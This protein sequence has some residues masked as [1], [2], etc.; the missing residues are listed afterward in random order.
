MG[1]ASVRLPYARLHYISYTL[2]A[3]HLRRVHHHPLPRAGRSCSRGIAYDTLI[4]HAYVTRY[5]IPSSF[6]GLYPLF[7]ASGRDIPESINRFIPIDRR[8]SGLNHSNG[9]EHSQRGTI[10]IDYLQGD[11]ER[12]ITAGG[13]RVRCSGVGRRRSHM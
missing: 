3:L 10:F 2:L 11:P 8:V 13:G 5:A 7:L 1:N 9:T 6:V 4:L 12:K